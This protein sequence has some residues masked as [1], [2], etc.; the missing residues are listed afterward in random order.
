MKN[1][2]ILTAIYC[3]ALISIK[4]QAQQENTDASK[5][6][7]SVSIASSTATAYGRNDFITVDC[8]QSNGKLRPLHG[9]NGGVLVRRE[10]INLSQYWNQM[11]VPITRLHDMPWCA[12][13]TVD[14]H[15]IFPEM[16][17]NPN[18]EKNY[19]FL[20]TDDFIQPIITGKME[21]N[22]DLLP[23]ENPKTE[24]VYRL[25]ESIEHSR[26]K[27]YVRPPGDFNK[28]S[29]VC[30]GIIR[31]YNEGW[32]NG[33]HDK[34]KYWEIWNEAENQNPP[35]QWT[36]NNDE[37]FKLYAVAAR[38][39]KTA[40]PDLKIGGPAC[41]VQGEFLDDKFMPGKYLTGFMKGCVDQ[42][43]PLDFFSWHTYTNNPALYKDK[44]ILLRNWLN[45]NGYKNTELHLN[46]WNYAP[47]SGQGEEWY[48][49]MGGVEGAAF[50]AY[51]LLSLQDSPVDVA[52]YY[53]ADVNPYGMFYAQAGGPKKVFYA[54][55]AFRFLLNTPIIINTIDLVPKKSIVTIARNEENNEITFMLVNFNNPDAKIKIRLIN[56]PWKGTTSV[57]TYLID[58]THNFES[59]ETVEI[60]EQNIPLK[61]SPA[62][63]S[64]TVIHLK[65]TE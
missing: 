49:R 42:N 2:L 8:R 34:I 12:D 26:R 37:Y 31:H 20:L 59:V 7:L 54:F 58:D 61:L 47:P 27:T 16:S 24:I 22:T 25:G 21:I 62:P 44:A 35:T 30:L 5:P 9:V 32:A 56:L 4:S 51:V 15:T 14:V 39:I 19:S 1:T 64:V 29:E 18:R 60:K 50:S 45:Q 41:G 57:S 38:K 6:L 33:Y 46:E 48:N 43:L 11:D 53:S 63:Y 28:W 23:G 36:G 3:L 65:S 10:F 55:K 17:K 13:E 40:F 52:N